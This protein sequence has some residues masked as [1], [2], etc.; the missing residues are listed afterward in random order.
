VVVIARDGTEA[1]AATWVVPQAGGQGA[2]INGSASVPDNEIAT[3]AIR[4]QTDTPLVS[5]P[6]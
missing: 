6:V 1:T 5:M 3:I 4:D 2:T